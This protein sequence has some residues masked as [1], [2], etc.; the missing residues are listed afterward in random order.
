MAFKTSGSGRGI[1]YKNES[2]L[3]IDLH[4][5]LLTLLM[6]GYVKGIWTHIQNEGNFS[7]TPSFAMMNLMRKSGKAVGFPDYVFLW[8]GKGALI[9]LKHNKN[10]LSEPQKIL[11]EWANL[12]KVPAKVC[13]SVDECINFL[14]EV[15]F[16]TPH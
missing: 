7:K 13:Y 4:T 16:I 1:E 6:N 12:T 2:K 3:A 14:K 8:E 15:G 11:F 5:E 9:E 10:K